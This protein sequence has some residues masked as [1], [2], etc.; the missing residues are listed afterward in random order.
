MRK[1][2]NLNEHLPL[3]SPNSKNLEFKA[4]KTEGFKRGCLEDWVSFTQVV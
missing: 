3:G 2:I 4:Q 1:T